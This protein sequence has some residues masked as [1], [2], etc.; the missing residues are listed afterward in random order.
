[1]KAVLSNRIY[2]G[3]ARYN[4]RQSVMPHYR[5]TESAQGQAQKTGRRYRPESEWVWS[6]APALIS[7][8]LFDKAQVQLQRNADLSRR[9]YQPTSGRYLLRRL[10]ACGECGLRLTCGQQRRPIS[11]PTIYIYTIIVKATT[12]SHA[13][14][15]R[16]VPRGE[17]VRSG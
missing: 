5:K 3:Q 17:C 16:P 9:Q 1:M 6:E 13:A 7:P 11:R 14:R 2:V 10:V 12:C 4:Y 15:L 8:E